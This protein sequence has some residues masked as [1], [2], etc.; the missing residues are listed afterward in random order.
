MFS[1]SLVACGLVAAVISAASCQRQEE[2]APCVATATVTLARDRAAIGSP[3]KATYRFD[4]ASNASIS[5]DNWVFVHVLD[6]QG[7]S[8]WGDDHV[9]SVPTSQWKP[10][11]KVEYTR[12]VFV[13]NYPY[14]GPAHIRIGLYQPSSGQRLPLCGTEISR[15]E[16]EVAKLQLLP[17]SENIFLIYKEGWHSSEISSDNPTVEWQWT[18]KTATISFR[19]P[20]KDATFYVEFDARVDKFNPPQQVTIRSGDQVIGTFAADAKDKKLLSFPVAAAQLGPAEM[21]EIT[22]ELNQIFVPGN[23]DNRELGIRIFHAF[24]EPK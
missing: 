6:D 2:S 9:P 18:K 10:G 8:L 4:V 17:Q 20:K 23:G 11:Q 14:I 16:Y 1:R 24:V 22:L 21:A 19:N 13:P 12:T 3:L 5:Q 15:R 7:E